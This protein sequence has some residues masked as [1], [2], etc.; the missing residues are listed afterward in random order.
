MLRRPLW[1]VLRSVLV[2]LAILTAASAARAQGARRAGSVRL[3]TASGAR[4]PLELRSDGDGYSGE[5]VIVNEG[6]EPLVV[7]RIAPRG[8]PADPHV[9]PKLA[10]RLASGTLPITLAPG[11]SRSATVRFTPSTR[12]RQLFGHV[13][14]TT[15]DE[16]SGEVAM[17]L[18][19][20]VPGPLGPLEPHL[21]SLLVGLPLL[22][23]LAAFALRTTGRRDDRG[24]RL[25][26][27]AALGLQALLAAYVYRG[28]IA[29]LSRADG[30]D[31]LQF[32]ERVVWIRGLFAELYLGVDGI[33]A[34]SLLVTSLVAFLAVLAEPRAGL[35]WSGYHAALLVLDAA[36]IGAIS[37]MDGLLFLLFSSIAVVVA[38]LLV[39]GWGGDG[40]R[41]AAMRLL[42]S[43]TFAITLLAV[44]LFAIGREADPTFLVDGTKV[45]TTTSL[46]ELSRVAIDAKGATLFGAP[47]VKVAFVLVTIASL[48]LLAAFPAHRWLSDVLASA[49]P[50]TG[51]LVATALPTIGLSAFLR[52][53][54]AVLPEGMRWASGVVVA[55]GAISAAYGALLALGEG[56]LRRLA[57]CATTSQAGFVLLG[58]GSLTPQGLSGAIVVGSTRALACSL[59]LLLA[60]AIHDRLRT[61]DASRLGGV[62]RQMPGWAAAL[63]IAALGQAG[64]LGLGGAWGPLLALL[65]VLSGYAPLAIAAAIALVVLAAAHLGLV[66]RVAFA[67]VDPGWAEDPA[68]EPLGGRLPDLTPREWMSVAPL[69]V[70]VMVLGLWPTPVLSTTTGTVRDLANAVSPPGPDQVATR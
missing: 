69:A 1:H 44:A 48:L 46:P 66:S 11:A 53:G 27:V 2:V 12:Q 67:P 30:N 19:A 16:R 40:R 18:R 24:P 38:G 42:V 36:L 39:G 55:L 52:V 28:F 13:V 17:G 4:G 21:L 58:A 63:A 59:L 22:G 32:V 14:V 47:L 45:T 51:I 25:A 60:S 34:T 49:P 65:G 50:A 5:I 64:V 37:A 6:K 43:G 33:A 29:D 56:D 41:P 15:S 10:A 3:E 62:A 31:G 68:L 9:Q 23:A 8:E 70:L 35:G 26:A 57:A 61:V 7:S 54:C 20:Q